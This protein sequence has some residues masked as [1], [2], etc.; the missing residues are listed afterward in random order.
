MEQPDMRIEICD[1]ANT[2]ME[3]AI[4]G[5][6]LQDQVKKERNGSFVVYTFQYLCALDA[7]K[8]GQ[9]FTRRLKEVEETV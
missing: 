1:P 9:S 6:E 4:S 5:C 7:F 2:I 8:L 3:Y